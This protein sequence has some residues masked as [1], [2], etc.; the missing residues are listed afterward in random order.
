[1]TLAWD[2]T[3]GIVGYRLYQGTESGIYTQTNDLGNITKTT[4]PGLTIGTTYYFVVTAYDGLGLESPFSSELMVSVAAPQPPPPPSALTFAADSGSIT[5]PF[6]TSNGTV[7]QTIETDVTTGGRAGY[8]FT[9]PAAGQYVVSALVSA[10]HEGA[11]SFYVN[12]DAEPT[13]PMMNWDIP[14]AAGFT[15]ETV[16]WRGNGTPDTAQFRPQVFSLSAGTHELI[17]RGREADTVLGTITISPYG[18]ASNPPPAIVLA[19][20][21]GGTSYTAPATINLAANVTANGH[22]ITK[23]QFYNGST[24]LAEDT[25]S[26]YTF[27]WANVGADTYVLSA[28]LVYDSGTTVSSA[29]TTVSVAAPPPPP[30]P[31]SALIFAADSGSITVPFVTSN[32]TIFQTIETDVTTGGRAAYSFTVQAAGQY[33][34]SALVSAPHEGA[35]S[36]YVNIDGEPTDPMMIWDIPVAAGFTHET[37]SWRDNGTPDIEQ[38]TPQVFSLS[39]GTHQLIVGGRE[40]DTVLGTITISPYG[41]P[42]PAPWQVVDIGTPGVSGSASVLNGNYTV[43]GAGNLGD[44]ADNFSFVYQPMTGD[45]EIRVQISSVQNTSASALA[46]VIMREALTPGSQLAFVGSSPSGVVSGQWRAGTGTASDSTT[47][48]TE[49]FP[50]IWV[51]LVR[52]G[53]IFYGYVSSDGVNYALVKSGSIP[54]ATTIYFGFAVVSGSTSSVNTSTFR[55]AAV[56]P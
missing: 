45:G 20:P 34:V 31:P 33:V 7:F 22:T 52:S 19:A 11:N 41:V 1:M 18:V 4:V 26:P 21:T 14:V 15:N 54:M 55:N 8:S 30:P 3:P 50:N 17:I 9:V 24:L 44:S 12:I 53:D 25:A 48:G 46:G 42:P 51:R 5:V 39:A 27:T 23:V 29:P 37:V 6:V 56:I 32:G 16:F 43:S 47:A 38:F 35:N 40:A 49:A 2:P 13:D 36:F 10:P 28:T